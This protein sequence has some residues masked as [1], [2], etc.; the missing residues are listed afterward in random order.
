MDI[1]WILFN[2]VQGCSNKKFQY[3]KVGAPL[4]WH[5]GRGSTG[6]P[7][8]KAVSACSLAGWILQGSYGYEMI[9]Q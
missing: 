8:L 7:C 6:R 9:D 3:L 1:V 4:L 5:P 2:D